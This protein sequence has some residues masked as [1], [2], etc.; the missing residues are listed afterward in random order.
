[1]TSFLTLKCIH[2]LKQS[3]WTVPHEPEHKQGL[4]RKLSL[5]ESSYKQILQAFATG[6]LVESYF[7]MERSCP[8]L[9]LRSFAKLMLFP[10]LISLM[11]N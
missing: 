5:V 11:K 3:I 2:W 1:M 9:F 7:M 8:I 6:S 4:N 10:S